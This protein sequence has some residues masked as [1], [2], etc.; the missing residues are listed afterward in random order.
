MTFQIAAD[1]AQAVMQYFTGQ[2]ALVISSASLYVA[3]L[4]GSPLTSGS[5]GA[6][7]VAV[8]DLKEDTT[9]GYARQAVTFSA[10]AVGTPSQVSNTGALTYN[11]SANMA[12]PVQ[13]AALV[14]SASGTTGTLLG[15]WVLDTIE[16]VLT[17][18]SIIIPA[19]D[20]I[21]D[22]Q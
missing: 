2:S 14:T 1:G 4:T 13:W 15:W 7:A 20:L 18:Q 8:A 12:A 22:Q 11:Y 9:T 21:I 16:Q 19:G 17:S 5:F 10:P 3:L 6:A